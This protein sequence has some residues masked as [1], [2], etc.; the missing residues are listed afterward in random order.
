MKRLICLLVL[1]VSPAGA[2]EPLT[3]YQDWFPGPQFAGLYVA[4][5]RG[6]Y[7][8]EGVE[9]A[10]HPFAFGQNVP[11]LMDADVSRAAIGTLEGYILLQKRARGADLVVLNAVLRES[12]AGYMMLPGK[13][14]A[15]ALDFR[16][17]RIGVHKYGDPLYRLFLRRAGM[18]PSA[19]TM[20]FVDDDLGRLERGEVDFMQGYAIEEL[21]KLRRARPGAGFLS[22]RE[23]G[24]DAYSQVIF[25]TRGQL[26]S[27]PGALRA[28]IEGTRR[29]WAYALA[30]P[31][32]AVDAVMPRMAVGTERALVREM[33]L[34]TGP[35]VASAGAPPL[36]PVEASKW[37]SMSAACVEMGLLPRAEDPAA[38][39]VPDK[40]P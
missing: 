1:A 25:S 33:F 2:S 3:Y 40:G 38:F 14:A 4:L 13:S 11:A 6:F 31:D 22:F 28:F 35:F 9:L 29:G 39:V 15:S 19:A 10:V 23:L 37:S 17:K 20:V 7:R 34:A 30:H 12:P 27:H 26:G 21:V 5:D 32:A 16:G 18:E 24:F 8:E 36:G